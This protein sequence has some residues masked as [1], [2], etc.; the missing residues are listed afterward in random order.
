MLDEPTVGQDR[1][2]RENLAR[3]LALMCTRGYGVM[4][5]THDDDFAAQLPHQVLQV[6]N[7]TISRR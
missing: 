6:S 7:L 5:V 1:D 2:T 4:F 3:H